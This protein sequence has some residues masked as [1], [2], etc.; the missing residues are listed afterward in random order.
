MTCNMGTLHTL[1][2]T[3]RTTRYK[4]KCHTWNWCVQLRT[5]CLNLSGNNYIVCT[6]NIYKLHHVIMLHHFNSDI[7]TWHM[8]KINQLIPLCRE[9]M[10][11]RKLYR[12]NLFHKM[13]WGHKT[14]LSGTG[15]I[16]WY[17]LAIVILYNVRV[18]HECVYLTSL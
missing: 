7:I 1:T 15:M 2:F 10:S 12:S 4:H 5:V 6:W 13:V 17:L 11:V 8:D 16:S 3:H 18:T 14:F 9:R